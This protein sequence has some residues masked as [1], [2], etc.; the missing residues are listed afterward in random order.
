MR[1][2]GLLLKQKI[3]S[4][5]GIVQK[6]VKIY[7]TEELEKMTEQIAKPGC[8]DKCG[9]V[10][11]PYPF[12]IGDGCFRDEWFNLTCRDGSL[13]YDTFPVSNISIL[14]SYMTVDHF[15]STDCSSN[16]ILN[17]GYFATGGKFTL[18]S[19]KNKLTAIGCNTH[20]F[21]G[22]GGNK[23]TPAGC[24]SICNAVEDS[25]DGYCTG[26]GSCQ[27]SVPSGLTVYNMTVGS[28]FEFPRNLGFN[29][30][31]YAFLI[32][33][34]SF[35]FSSSYL[36][37]FKNNGTG[38]VPVSIDWTIG[39]ETCEEAVRNLTSYA[40]GPNT[41]V[42]QARM[43]Q[44]IY[45]ER[46]IC[47]NTEGRFICQNPLIPSIIPIGLI[48]SSGIGV[49]IVIVLMLGMG[50]W[51]Y[52]RFQK[53]KLMKLKQ[54][55]LTRNG[56]LLLKQKITS[57]E[58]LEK[59]T[60]NFNPSRIVGKGGYGTVFKGMLSIVA[61]KKSTLVDESQVDQFINEVAILSQI[62]HRHIVKLLGCCLETQVPLLVY[63]FVPNG[64][65]SYHLHEGEG[66]NES[67]LSWKDRVRIA[68]EIAGALAYLHSDAFMAIFHR[69]IKSTNIL[70]DEKYKAKVSDF[71]I[72]RSAPIDSTH[73]TTL[74][75]GTF[76]YLDPEY[77]HSGQF[78]DKSDVYSF[79]IALVELL[80][81]EQALSLLE[82]FLL[83]LYFVKSV[84]ENR[85]SEILD[86]RVFNEGDTN[87]VL[88][89]GKLA[90]KC[91]KYVGKK[92]PTMK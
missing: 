45:C 4:N 75:Q 62:N 47:I 71:G 15:I 19:T 10:S 82:Y 57:N 70:L 33:E 89:V 84:K 77:F 8:Q 64:T 85:L 67:L 91:L 22:L 42:Y 12:G 44:V 32:E 28:I 48:V 41:T 18:S 39:N 3:T 30:C 74:V 21:L 27:A 65:L 24:L 78:T 17:L 90:K 26:I 52:N 60:D 7:V 37:I 63:E 87:D 13:R 50:Y 51:L 20:A 5:N 72:S 1:N 35:N 54:D 40:C 49:S 86:V 76:G 2:G 61:I 55:H 6:T 58:E 88:L 31:T 79:G 66:D 53:R 25:T 73:L 83:A 29:P 68:S 56:G 80:T 23:F 9:N 14:G 11:I 92:R 34:N 59:T 46:G 16:H 81:G 36:K 38:T 69:E 43:R